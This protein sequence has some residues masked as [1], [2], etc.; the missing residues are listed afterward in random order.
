MY[1]DN[2]ISVATMISGLLVG[3]GVGLAVLFKMNKGLKENIK[4]V[5]LLYSIGV[6][7]GILLEL[8]CN[9]GRVFFHI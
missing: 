8:M 7:A 3:A 4:I 6:I 1:L 2:I 5:A 9:W